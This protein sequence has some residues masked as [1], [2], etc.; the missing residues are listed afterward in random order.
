MDMGVRNAIDRAVSVH[1][2][3]TRCS[4][5]SARDGLVYQTQAGVLV[6][7]VVCCDLS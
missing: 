6:R 5:A 4:R 3:Q 2:S 1:R 7:M